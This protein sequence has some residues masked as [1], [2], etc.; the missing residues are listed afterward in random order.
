MAFGV[1]ERPRNYN[2][3]NQL[4]VTYIYGRKKNPFFDHSN[5]I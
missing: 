3:S 2:Y 5:I 4:K 1:E